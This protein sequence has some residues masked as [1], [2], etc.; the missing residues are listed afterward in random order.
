MRMYGIQ[1]EGRKDILSQYFFFSS[2][3]F[4]CLKYFIA[5]VCGETVEQVALEKL[6][7]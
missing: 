1:R 2:G 3:I 7:M 4:L 6:C 5:Y